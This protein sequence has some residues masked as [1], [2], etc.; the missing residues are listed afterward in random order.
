MLG[1]AEESSAREVRAEREREASLRIRMQE[2]NARVQQRT[3]EEQEAASRLEEL[4]QAFLAAQQAHQDSQQAATQEREQ[5]A[6]LMAMLEPQES[7]VETA[8]NY[9]AKVQ[10]LHGS[11]ADAHAARSRQL[12]V[13]HDQL[14]AAGALG[15]MDRASLDILLI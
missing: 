14:G 6:A 9:H 3:V 2:Q 4:R 10:T 5:Q 8:R 11:V 13:V 7:A 15:R 12:R 1:D